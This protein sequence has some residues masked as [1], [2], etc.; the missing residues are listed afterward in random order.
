MTLICFDRP[1]RSYERPYRL[2]DVPRIARYAHRSGAHWDQ[3]VGSV[4]LEAG[5]GPDVCNAAEVVGL[6]RAVLG[7]GPDKRDVQLV[8]RALRV[9]S[10]VLPARLKAIV[11]ALIVVLT[12]LVAVTPDVLKADDFL[13][14]LCDQVKLQDVPRGT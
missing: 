7:A 6:L 2:S 13:R 9:A 1:N 4:L 12:A 5:Y 11:L 14:R 8:I 10:L 3:I